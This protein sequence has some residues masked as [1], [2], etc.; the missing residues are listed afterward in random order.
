MP[1]QAF[2]VL[3]RPGRGRLLNL[4]LVAVLSGLSVLASSGSGMAAPGRRSQSAP[5]PAPSPSPQPFA[6]KVWSTHDYLNVA[7]VGNLLINPAPLKVFNATTGKL[8]WQ[9]PYRNICWAEGVSDGVIVLAHSSTGDCLSYSADGLWA[10]SAQTGKRL[11]TAPL[12]DLDN[13]VVDAGMVYAIDPPATHLIAR[14]VTTGKVL[15]SR[16]SSGSDQWNAVDSTGGTSLAAETLSSIVI[17]DRTSGQVR[18]RKGGYTFLSPTLAADGRQVYAP[19]NIVGDQLTVFNGQSGALEWARPDTA[20]YP[21]STRT[22]LFTL[23]AK[24][25]QVCALN[26]ATG[27]LLWAKTL[28]LNDLFPVAGGGYVIVPALSSSDQDESLVLRPSDGTVLGAIPG[29]VFVVNGDLVYTD[30]GD[31]TLVYRMPTPAS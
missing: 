1:S 9:Q 2:Q 30:T 8:D 14:N 11:W 23:C 15:W 16:A 24:R 20:G 17:L 26:R 22:A 19:R 7:V 10:V 13:A 6:T 3:R 29:D 5:A 4:L 21:T 18:W 28:P 27:A 31:H 12:N 25:T